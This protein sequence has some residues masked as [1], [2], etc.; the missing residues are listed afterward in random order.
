MPTP[1]KAFKTANLELKS[2]LKSYYKM[3]LNFKIP[4][5]KHQPNKEKI[6]G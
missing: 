3:L 5:K 2:H 1:Q 4:A 6:D